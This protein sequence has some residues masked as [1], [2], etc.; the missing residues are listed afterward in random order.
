MTPSQKL[1]CLFLDQGHQWKIGGELRA[2]EL[3]EFETVLERLIEGV[4]TLEVERPSDT[5]QI[6]IGH[7]IA[8]RLG[9]KVDV[10]LH[11]DVTT[12]LPETLDTPAP[13]E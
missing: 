3:E 9:T 1:Y 5:A 13:G 12:S 2:P 10:F 6:E 11:V 8:R 7:L 4:R